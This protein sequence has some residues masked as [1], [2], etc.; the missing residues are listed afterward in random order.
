MPTGDFDYM[1]HPN[2]QRGM[3]HCHDCTQARYKTS[4]QGQMEQAMQNKPKIERCNE[5]VTRWSTCHL[6]KGHEGQH[7]EDPPVFHN[8]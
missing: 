1:A 3:C 8:S 5:W 2:E 4:L 7:V 6:V